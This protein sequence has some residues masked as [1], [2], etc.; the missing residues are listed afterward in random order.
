MAVESPQALAEL[1]YEG[2]A[3]TSALGFSP[4]E[5]LENRRGRIPVSQADRLWKHT[6]VRLMISVISFIVLSTMASL[7]VLVSVG[8]LRSSQVFGALEAIGIDPPVLYIPL[9][10][11]ILIVVAI[12]VFVDLWFGIRKLRALRRDLKQGQ[13]GIA[14]GWASFSS[15]LV[16]GFSLSARCWLVVNKT[17]FEVTTRGAM[18]L[19]ARGPCRVYYTPSSRMV[20]S[21]E[22]V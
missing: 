7:M 10:A 9:A 19:P 17:H 3:F 2:D 12:G 16:W 20:L 8:V 18:E 11:V 21:V 6:G 5:L 15:E 13:T 14:E 4:A 1:R 22:A